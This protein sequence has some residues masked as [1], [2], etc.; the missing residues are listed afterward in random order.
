MA[1]DAARVAEYLGF[2]LMGLHAK[3]RLVGLGT[4]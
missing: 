2:G 1:T 4:R 3:L